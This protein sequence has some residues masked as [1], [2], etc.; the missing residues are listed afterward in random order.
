MAHGHLDEPLDIRGEDEIGQ[1]SQAFEQMRSSLKARL[2]ELNRLLWVSQKA[3]ASLEIEDALSPVLESA[4]VTGATA[5]RITL[6]PELFADRGGNTPGSSSFEPDLDPNLT[7]SGTADHCLIWPAEPDP[8]RDLT[9]PRLLALTPG[10]PHPQSLL[11]LALREESVYYGTLWI[12]FSQPHNF[13]EDEIR[14]LTT[15]A[16]QAALAAANV[17]LFQTAELGRQ[18]L[19]A[20]LA[21]T[22]DP[23][24]VTDHQERLL[25]TNPAADQVLG[26]G[27]QGGKGQR[28]ESSKRWLINLW[29]FF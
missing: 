8:N 3:T 11:A 20:I 5:A 23:V 18:R 12:G 19:E 16:G 13:E 27:E 7:A 14:Y 26:F 10:N 29:L 15:L 24:L 17:R 2:D 4:L 25:L 1:L 28:I 9:R 21:S 6:V 22:P